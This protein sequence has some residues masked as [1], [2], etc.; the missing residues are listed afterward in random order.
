MLGRRS[1]PVEHPFKAIPREGSTDPA[2]LSFGATGWDWPA[3]LVERVGQRYVVT[4]ACPIAMSLGLRPGMVSAHARALVAD[5]DVRDAEPDADR[6]WLDRLAPHAVGH[7]T[8]TA[9]V[10]G[11]DGLWFDLTGTTHLFGGENRFCQWVIRFLGRL[12]FTARIAVAGTP[13]AA[14]A[15]ARYGGGASL[16]LDHGREADALAELPVS[17]LRLEPSA[18][19]AAARFGLDRIA[20]LICLPRG[21]LAR[22]LGLRTVTRLDQALGH[23]AEPIIPVVPC[24]PTS[25]EIWPSTRAHERRRRPRSWRQRYRLFFLPTAPIG[26]RQPSA[27]S[28]RLDRI[29]RQ[30]DRMEWNL[31]LSNETIALFI[32]FWL[33]ANPPMADDMRAAAQAMGKERWEHFVEALG[34]RMEA[35]PRLFDEISRDVDEAPI[36]GRR[37]S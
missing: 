5:L 37:E 22:R 6:A 13:G 27:I 29:G 21:P 26:W 34:R 20:D 35:G 32:R 14:H 28:R 16:C 15:L 17:A 2:G 24:D 25:R 19:M 9:N 10:S 18:L 7:W 1:E 8:P 31:G 4:A 11:A 23:V 33:T 12:G 36:G 3:I 30:L